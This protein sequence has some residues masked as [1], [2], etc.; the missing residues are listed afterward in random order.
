MPNAP[1]WS[2]RQKACLERLRTGSISDVA[3]VLRDLYLTKRTKE[4]SIAERRLLETT[5]ELFVTEAPLATR[6]TE[7]DIDAELRT[8]F[9]L[10]KSA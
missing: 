2:K 8:I 1:T 5:H 4:P 3:V 6:R 10:K 9:R 7:A